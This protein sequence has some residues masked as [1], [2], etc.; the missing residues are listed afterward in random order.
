LE[1]FTGER[2]ALAKR[3]RDEGDREAAAERFLHERSDKS[4]RQL[5]DWLGHPDPAFSVRAYAGTMDDG[6]G[7]AEFLDE[8][9]PVEGWAT[10][11]QPNTRRQ[12]QTEDEDLGLDASNCGKPRPAANSRKR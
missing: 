2:N 4:D 8:L 6:L 10:D 3:L 12:P 5:C 7:S 1:E 11:G 9:I